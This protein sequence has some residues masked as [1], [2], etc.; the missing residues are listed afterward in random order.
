MTG[1]RG[2]RVA[3]AGALIVVLPLA[4]GACS[5]DDEEDGSVFAIKPGQCFLAPSEVE[6]QISDLERVDCR[7]EHDHEAYA[8]VPYRAPGEEPDAE[9]SDEFP[10]D[11]ALTKFADGA[12]AEEFGAYVGVDYLDSSLFYTYLTPSPRSWQEEDRSVICLVT[13]AGT[14]LTGSVKGTEQ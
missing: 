12:C 11:E 9:G 8:V 6:A 3:R 14:Q 13:S 4:L 5:G 7:K 10:G 2:R 1:A